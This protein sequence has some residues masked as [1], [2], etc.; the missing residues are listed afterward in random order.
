MK[1]ASTLLLILSAFMFNS[2]SE[3]ES[4]LPALE[5]NGQYLIFG[6]FYG[7]CAGDDCVKFLMIKDGELYQLTQNY[8]NQNQP[9]VIG[10]YSKLSDEQYELVKDVI[11]TIPNELY[12]VEENVLGCPDCADGGGIYLETLLNGQKKYWYIDNT[13]N[14][15]AYLHNL[16]QH[17]NEKVNLFRE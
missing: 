13:L 11:S 9:I 3:K 7:F 17:V 6:S 4:E 2:C 12:Q 5:G 16:I 15:P 10:S 1:R 14:E 8:P